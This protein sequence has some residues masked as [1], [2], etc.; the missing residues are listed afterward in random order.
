MSDGD[1]NGDVDGDGDLSVNDTFN[2]VVK[3]VVRE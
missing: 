3:K 2:G 1:I